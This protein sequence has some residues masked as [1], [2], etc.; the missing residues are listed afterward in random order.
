MSKLWEP[1]RIGTME[2]KNRFIMAPMFTCMANAGGE[3]S[4]EIVEYY[5]RRAKGGA[6]MIIVEIAAVHPQGAI[7]D[8]ELMLCDDRFIPGM[9]RIAEAIKRHDCRAVLQVHHPGRQADS[10][11]TGNETV[12]PSAV[13]WAAFADVPRELTIGEVRELVECYAEAARRTRDAGFD[14]VQFHG[15][16]GYLICQFFSPLSNQRTDEYGGDVHKRAKFGVDIVQLARE[17]LGRDYPM[18]FRISGSEIE[19][20]GLTTDQTSVIAK[21]LQNAGADCIDVSAG[22]YGTSEWTSQPP[23]MKP[24]CIVQYAKEIKPSVDVPVITVGKI[25]TPRLAHSILEEGAADLIALG[26]PLLADPDYP[27]KA[28]QGRENEIAKCIACNTCMDLVFLR[29]PI[30]C[31]QNPYAGYESEE[32][33]EPRAASPRRALVIGEGAAAL[34]AARVAALRGHDTVLWKTKE[35]PGGHWSWLIHGFVNEKLKAA[36][37]A[38]AKVE[39]RDDVS[40]DMVRELQPD[41]VLIEKAVGPVVPDIPGAQGENVVQAVDMLS[42]EREVSGKVVI[43]GAGNTGVQTALQLGRKGAQITILASRRGPAFEIEQISRKILVQK[44][45]DLGVEML[46]RCVATAIDADGLTY[47]DQGGEQNR[48]QADYVVLALGMETESGLAES[49]TSAG[50]ETVALEYCSS[51]RSVYAAVREGATAAREV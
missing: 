13:P 33:K 18:L 49:I 22:Y 4:D 36:A 12:G 19:Q 10:R 6:A 32:G 51:Q 34:E 50:Y 42:G 5:E 23:F 8:R 16:H 17:K 35:Q 21:L 25:N 7:C 39:Q 48:L 37:D 44:L 47:E 2:L 15:A 24:G 3:V 20:G 31:V 11:V 1:I 46:F 14:G 41:V 28:K 27:L 38:G 43:L 45:T 40:I 9:A 29:K 30:R 26:R